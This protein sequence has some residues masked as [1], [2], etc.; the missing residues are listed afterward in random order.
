VASTRQRR[1]Q[2]LDFQEGTLLDLQADLLQ[3]FRGFEHWGG[4]HTSAATL[5]DPRRVGCGRRRAA[6]R[7]VLQ[8]IDRRP[9][10]VGV[11]RDFESANERIGEVLRRL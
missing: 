3:I 5:D 4:L 1:Q 7:R 9:G 2:K 10:Q 8:A 11:P 6:P